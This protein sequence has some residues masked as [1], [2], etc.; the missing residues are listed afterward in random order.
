MNKHIASEWTMEDNTEYHYK[1]SKIFN[2]TLL[3]LFAHN[4]YDTIIFT[5]VFLLN[6]RENNSGFVCLPRGNEMETG[7][8]VK[9]R[10]RR[11]RIS[12]KTATKYMYRERKKS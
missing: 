6:T 10:I 2:A 8:Q 3:L 4:F 7:D 9:E 1:T 11:D 12:R 5:A